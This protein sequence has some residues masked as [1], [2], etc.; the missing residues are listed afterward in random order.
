MTYLSTCSATCGVSGV[1]THSVLV[2]GEQFKAFLS[3]SCVYIYKL[4]GQ[5]SIMQVL[6]LPRLDKLP[7]LKFLD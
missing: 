4:R 5:Q 2:T 7:G 1:R 6:C 3:Q